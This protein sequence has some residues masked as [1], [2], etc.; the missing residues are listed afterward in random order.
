MIQNRI[1]KFQK[2]WKTICRRGKKMRSANTKKSRLKI[3]NI[4]GC[5][6]IT[7]FFFFETEAKALPHS[8][9][10]QKVPGF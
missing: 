4:L 5:A 6:K 7:K 10:K 2:I 3:P 9:I 1:L 8:F